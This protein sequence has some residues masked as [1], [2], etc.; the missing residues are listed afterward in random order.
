M[1]KGDWSRCFL[2]AQF[3]RPT[4]M[5]FEPANPWT[6][7]EHFS[8]ELPIS[9]YSGI[10]SCRPTSYGAR[11]FVV[12]RFDFILTPKMRFFN[13]AFSSWRSLKIEIYRSSGRA[14]R[15]FREW[16]CLLTPD[17]LVDLLQRRSSWWRRW[18]SSRAETRTNNIYL[19]RINNLPSLRRRASSNYRLPSESREMW[20]A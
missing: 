2:L 13:M 1:T 19:T 3:I 14:W 8:I 9:C 7:G 16:C 18:S 11:L 20:R 5:D 12:L 17:P 10:Y 6:R 15:S 4:L